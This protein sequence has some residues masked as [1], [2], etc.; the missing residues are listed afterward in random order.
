MICLE[1]VMGPGLAAPETP[2]IR[3][4][5]WVVIVLSL[6]V[7]VGLL[8]IGAVRDW[9]SPVATGAVFAVLLVVTALVAAVYFVLKRRRD[10]KWLDERCARGGEQ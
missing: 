6:A 4:L 2:A 8:L 10:D 7:V 9:L 5:R 3:R 1:K